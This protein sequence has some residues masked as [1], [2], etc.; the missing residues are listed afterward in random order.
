MKKVISLI[1]TAT[2]IS[3]CATNYPEVQQS[4]NRYY[5][6]KQNEN[7][8]SIAFAFEISTEQLRSA[9]P[10]LNPVNIGTGMRLRIPE[11]SLTNIGQVAPVQLPGQT[12]DF[13]WPLNEIDVSSDFGYR[14]GDQHNGIDLRAPRGTE[15]YASAPGRVI[16]SGRKN[17]YGRMVVIRHGNGIETVYAHNDQNIAKV[18]QRVKQG[19]L[20]G[21]VGKSGN[22]TGYH[23]H[24]EF[25]RQ[26]RSVDPVG[27]INAGL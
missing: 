1:L 14:H 11:N 4:Q 7:F 17:G 25:R 13:I 6:V 21:R 8:D 9:N 2:V 26:G 19:Q 16:F 22:A 27:Y 18:G 12:S 23:V 20:V 15:I 24:F 5:V 10:W 3:A